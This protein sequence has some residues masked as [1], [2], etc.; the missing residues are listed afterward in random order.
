MLDLHCHILPGVDDGPDSL[1]ESLEVARLFVADGITYATAT[2][3]C[4]RHIR[5]LRATIVPAVER[6]NAALIRE[7]IPLTVLPGAEIQV[8]SVA[9]YQRDYEAGVLCHLGDCP[10]FSLTE[11]PWSGTLYPQGASELIGW[12]LAR[13]TR[14][15][16]AHPERHEYFRSDPARLVAL[17]EAG[18]WIQVTVDSLLGVNGPMA[19]A[20]GEGFLKIF[21]NAVLA[22]DAH[23]PER[24]SGLTPGYARVRE[25]L[26]DARADDLRQR[27]DHI[28]KTLLAYRPR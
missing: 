19:Q 12:L 27:S 21:P 11:F 4:H 17:T 2:P 25:R 15:V 24:C 6:L 22:T 7:G 5:S 18:A 8:T 16:I 23:N 14:A 13:G 28:L 20:A 26:G 9:D 3:H 1:E 10:A